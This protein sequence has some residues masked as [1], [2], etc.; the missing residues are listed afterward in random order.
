M[1]VLPISRSGLFARR[2]IQQL[3]RAFISFAGLSGRQQLT[4]QSKL[5]TVDEMYRVRHRG[6]WRGDR[7]TG[8][9]WGPVKQTAPSLRSREGGAVTSPAVARQSSLRSHS[10]VALRAN[11]TS[12]RCMWSVNCALWVVSVVVVYQYCFCCCWKQSVLCSGEV[13]VRF[14]VVSF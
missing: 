4:W 13:F 9:K 14:G 3:K 12:T 5:R 10:T 8:W 7:G 6:A 1:I 2:P 11:L